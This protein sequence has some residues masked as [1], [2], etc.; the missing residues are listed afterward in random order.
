MSIPAGAKINLQIKNLDGTNNNSSISRYNDFSAF[1]GITY[2]NSGGLNNSPRINFNRASSQYLNSFAPITYN[3]TTNNGFT[4]ICAVRF[5]NL[6]AGER[7]FDLSNGAGNNNIIFYRNSLSN[8]MTLNIFNSSGSSIQLAETFGGIVNNEWAVWS[9]RYQASPRIAR[10]FKNNIQQILISDTGSAI[11]TDR[12][13]T[14]NWIGRSI[15][16]DPYF[17]GDMGSILVYDRYLSDAEY[18]QAYEAVARYIPQV[19]MT[20]PRPPLFR[21]NNFFQANSYPTFSDLLTEEVGDLRYLK[22][23]DGSLVLNRGLNIGGYYRMSNVPSWNVLR[24]SAT[25]IPAATVVTY[26]TT[27]CTTIGGVFNLSTGLFSAGVEGL[28][29]VFFNSRTA[30]PTSGVRVN[31]VCIRVNSTNNLNMRNYNTATGVGEYFNGLDIYNIA[32]LK[33]GDTIG[34]YNNLGEIDAL[35]GAH[36]CGFYIGAYE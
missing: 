6:G 36:F 10:I 26:T 30:P 5:T 18:E 7:I 1:N 28:Y 25:R 20:Y 29:Y 8:N 14:S 12:I 16:G 24:A 22:Y 17:E 23:N 31:E 32:Y 21:F 15:F 19:G 27:Y 2:F 11:P 9:V 34:I 33:V 13:L 3:I 35:F 4:A